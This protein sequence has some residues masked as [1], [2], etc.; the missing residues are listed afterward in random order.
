M[1]SIRGLNGDFLIFLSVGLRPSVQ[2]LQ[3]CKFTSKC[4]SMFL[5][6]RHDTDFFLICYS[7]Q[8]SPEKE[9]ISRHIFICT[10]SFWSSLTPNFKI[11]LMHE[12][13]PILFDDRWWNST[14]E[15]CF[16]LKANKKRAFNLKHLCSNGQL[17][18]V[19]WEW[20][21]SFSTRPPCFWWDL[22][23]CLEQDASIP[24]GI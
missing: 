23:H 17:L 5:L 18:T 7:S 3:L 9:M 1:P 15:Q 4:S 19:F 20:A 8:K 22:K 2:S 10:F 11:K 13:T 12:S 21:A 16:T 24:G 6:S 14:V